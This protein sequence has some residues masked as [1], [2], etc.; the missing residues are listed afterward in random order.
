[1]PIQSAF[2]PLLFLFANSAI[3][4]DRFFILEIPLNPVFSDHKKLV[5]NSW[6]IPSE[7]AEKF[8]ASINDEGNRAKQNTPEATSSLPDF[9]SQLILIKSDLNAGYF[10][11]TEKLSPQTILVGDGWKMCCIN[12]LVDNKR[13]VKFYS[14][15]QVGLDILRLRDEK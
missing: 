5:V 10:I 7:L 14:L 9:V 15:G 2:L 8:Y 3:A 11:N 1:M 13:S 12:E 4:A 6:E